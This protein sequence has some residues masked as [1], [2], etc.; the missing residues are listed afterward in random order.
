MVVHD[1]WGGGG[2]EGEGAGQEKRKQEEKKGGHDKEKLRQN[3]ERSKVSRKTM[4]REAFELKPKKA[5]SKKRNIENS[6]WTKTW[7]RTLSK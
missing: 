5:I 1:V 4:T 6:S 2:S 3:K 7:R